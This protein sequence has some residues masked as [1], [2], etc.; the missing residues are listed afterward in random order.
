M[1]VVGSKI[2]QK[3]FEVDHM[4]GKAS[5]RFY[6]TQYLKGQAVLETKYGVTYASLQSGIGLYSAYVLDVFGLIFEEFDE[7][8]QHAGLTGCM[9]ITNEL[10]ALVNL[11]VGYDSKWIAASTIKERTSKGFIL[12]GFNLVEEI[13]LYATRFCF[14]ASS[15]TY[16]SIFAVSKDSKQMSYFETLQIQGNLM[17]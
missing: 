15:N 11:T 8:V 16:Y 3:Y 13:P 12:N 14:N 9:N 10:S 1:Q 7:Q 6:Y 4:L 17:I 5:S 2:I